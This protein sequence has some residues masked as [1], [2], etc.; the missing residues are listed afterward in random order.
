MNRPVP[1]WDP[2][3][4]DV[5]ADP[6]TVQRRL[7]EHC[8]VAW[9]ERH[10]GFWSLFRYAD[11]VAATKDPGSF[12]QGRPQRG[13][14]RPPL[15][16]NPPL[17]STYRQLLNPYFDRAAVLASTASVRS[18]IDD[19][20]APLVA[21]G[22]GDLAASFTYPLPTRVLCA[23]LH[24]PDEAW[25]LLDE[26]SNQIYLNE[27]GRGGKP[28]LVEAAEARLQ[29]F[30]L[31]LVDDRRAAPL[32]PRDDLVSGLIAAEVDGRPLTDD[33]IVQVLRLLFV[34]GHNSTT[35]SLGI[36]LLRIAQS[37][38]VQDR[39]RADPGLIPGAVSEF[40]RHETPVMA[41]P[42]TVT[43]DLEIGGRQLGEGDQAFLVWASGNRDP[44]VFDDAD[45]CVIDRRPNPHLVFG[46][47]IH[48]C[49]GRGLAEMEL[50][51]AI[52]EVLARTRWLSLAGPVER[53]S[54]VRFG[55]SS[56]PVSFH[57]PS[58]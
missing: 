4:P 16:V 41:M 48:A 20:L 19:L 40:L 46:R 45:E 27:E 22:G 25:L 26:L 39:L 49:I 50:R 13:T 44:E 6:V 17:H 43:H 52:E 47:G 37:E 57:G 35:S 11:I 15:E 14:P 36:C 56:L 1:D 10:G 54:W 18:V 51:V 30:A 34:A 21:A 7:R 32:D 9:T 5:V 8:P 33:E 55:V 53:T 24:L 2:L 58:S 3:A 12:A 28:E 42:R 31:R 23:F 38:E 29:D